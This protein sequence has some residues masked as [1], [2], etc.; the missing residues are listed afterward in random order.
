MRFLKILIATSVIAFVSTGMQMIDK[1]GLAYVI[2]MCLAVGTLA[3]FTVE[4][5]N[6]I[7]KNQ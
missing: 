3:A 7:N 2:T 4:A 1:Y 6:I 5:L